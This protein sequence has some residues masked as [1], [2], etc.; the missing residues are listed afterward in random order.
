MRI[1]VVSFVGRADTGKT[2]L[3][4]KLIPLLRSKGIRVATIKHDVHGFE[5]D[6][7]GKDTYRHKKAGAKMT[8]I[9]S[10]A[11][12]GLVEDVERDLGVEEIVSRYVRDV[13]LVITEGY[14]REAMPKIEVY[15]TRRN[16][17]PLAIDDKRLIAIVSNAPIV[18][19]VPVFVR[20]DIEAVCAFL[21]RQFD[22]P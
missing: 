15:D 2:T 22:L 21:M 4:E 1:P 10:P 7:E 6:H 9:S 16:E 17:P 19:P 3:I 8:I 12:V 14:K 5:M 13:D 18:A 20:D 11:K